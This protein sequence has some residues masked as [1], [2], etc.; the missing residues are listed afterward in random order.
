MSSECRGWARS[1][2]QENDIGNK[3]ARGGGTNAYTDDGFCDKEL[4]TLECEWDGGDCDE[5]NRLYPERECRVGFDYDGGCESFRSA[6]PNCKQMG[7]DSYFYYKLGNGWCDLKYNTANCEWD[8]GDC[9]EFNKKYPNCKIRDPQWLGNGV[10]SENENNAECGWGGGDCLELNQRYPNCKNCELSMV[11]DGT[12]WGLQECNTAECEW[13][14]GDC[15]LEGLPDC[16]MEPFW[17]MKRYIGDGKCDSEYNSIS[18][19]WDGGDCLLAEYPDCHVS[20]PDK[21]GDGYCDGGEYNSYECGGDGGDCPTPA[22]FPDCHVDIPYHI[23]DG[24]CDYG[25]YNTEWCG[26]DGGDC[27]K[28]NDMNPPETYNGKSSGATPMLINVSNVVHQLA[29]VG[30]ILFLV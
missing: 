22:L 13:E 4:N 5:F 25:E 20:N 28:A 6:Y 21:I 15:L 16:H 12:C 8:G 2:Y 30:A 23:G 27:L 24:L 10:C 19:G 17:K 11:S 9:L 3:V 7:D 18:C 26:W 1:Y 29:T 14:G